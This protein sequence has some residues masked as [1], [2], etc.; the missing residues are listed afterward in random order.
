MKLKV[1]L[2]L[3][4]CLLSTFSVWA[5]SQKYSFYYSQKLNEGISQLSV[6]T[7][8]QDTRGYL[9]LGTRNGLNRYNGSGYTVFR[10]HPGDS[11]SLADN[12]INDICEDRENYLWIAT[13]R[14]LSRMCLRTEHI[15]NYFVPDG[16]PNTGILSLLAD[17]SGRVWIGTRGG[18][19]RYL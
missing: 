16:L 8:C 11:L 4:L 6:M 19:C 18:L 3:F 14:G 1:F 12:E 5:G 13:S 17:T 9:W 15:R 7:I 2:F 10:H